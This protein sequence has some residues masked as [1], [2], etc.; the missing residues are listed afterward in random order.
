M[1]AAIFALVGTLLGILG[2]LM[3]EV[4]RTR[5]MNVSNRREALRLVCA[6]FTA[7]VARM[8]TIAMESIHNRPDADL[9]SL[10]HEAHREARIHYERLR[11]TAVSQDVQEAGRYVL[12][13]AYGLLRQME[14]K[15]PRD[16]E[17]ESG[18]IRMPHSSLITLYAAVRRE[19]GLPHADDVYSEPDEW[20]GDPGPE[21]TP[22]IAPSPS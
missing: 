14:S 11:L 22:R 19:T 10:M 12:R 17:R 6:D 5:A 9:M 4:V 1:T 8:R 2:T 21:P 13:Y 16:D 7:S 18:P 15:L 3:V 20:L